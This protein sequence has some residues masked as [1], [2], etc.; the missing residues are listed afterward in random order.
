MN[1]RFLPLLGLLSMSL[2]SCVDTEF[3][4]PQGAY[5]SG[6]FVDHVYNVWEGNTKQGYN[7]IKYAKT[8]SRGKNGYFAGNGPTDNPLECYGNLEAKQYHPDYFVN[9]AGEELHW[10]YYGGAYD[11]RPE[12]IINNGPGVYADN[13]PLYETVYSQN[14]RLDRFYPKFSRGYLS[15]L[16]N[17]QIKCN[18]WSYYAMMVLSSEGYGTMFP[19]E[20]ADATYFAT[21][22]LM[23]TDQEIDRRIV[24]SDIIVTFYKFAS[25]GLEGYQVRLPGVDLSCNSAA[26]RTSLVGFTFED[27]GISPRGIV[28]MSIT[29]E[30][31]VDHVVT[32]ASSDFTSEGYH[33]GL[34]VYEILFPDSTWY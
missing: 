21:S 2:C 1:K 13:S 8:L 22:V 31:L 10:G 14:K 29:Y 7:N 32:D 9:N 12:D 20:L 11:G 24:T 16:Y 26:A 18:G 28:G 19:Y 15:K 5:L 3:L 30:N 33:D 6:T 27:A 34:C 23:G 17:G 4:Y 25:V